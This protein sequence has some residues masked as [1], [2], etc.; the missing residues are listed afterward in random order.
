MTFFPYIWRIVNFIILLSVASNALAEH[1][2]SFVNTATGKGIAEI[3]TSKL[4]LE[5]S[6][7]S[8]IKLYARLIITDFTTANKELSAL[9]KSR[10]IPVLEDEEL[11]SQVKMIMLQIRDSE[12]F[13]EAYI[14][15]QIKMQHSI[16][17]LFE[18]ESGSP[19]P[20]NEEFKEFANKMLPKLKEHL[21]NAQRLAAS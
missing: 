7:S 9:A 21:K 16:I 5:K 15:N 14:N 1:P 10:N 17:E 20:Y 12:S 13:D 4:A 11:L 2:A 8:D 18:A 19:E 6:G 3:E